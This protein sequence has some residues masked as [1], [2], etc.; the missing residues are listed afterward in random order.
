MSK[1]LT[2]SQENYL[3]WIYR[4]SEKGAVRVRDLADKLGVRLPSVSRAISTLAKERLVKHESY[5]K[6]ELTDEGRLVGQNIVRR[7]EC[8]TRFLV[9]VL[10][11]DQS[12]ADP[13]VHR[14]EHVLSDDVLAR[15]EILTEFA[16]SSPAWIK[17]L[18]YRLSSVPSPEVGEDAYRVGEGQVHAGLA[19]EKAE[20]GTGD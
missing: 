18:H 3:E 12:A 14:L 6:I 5:G 2:A 20:T 19:S 4:F 9:S 13:E 16:E 11:M 8:L 7:D 1:T 15:L 10:G 17:R